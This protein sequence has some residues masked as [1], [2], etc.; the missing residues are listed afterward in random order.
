VNYANIGGS[1]CQ[2]F[3]GIVTTRIERRTTWAPVNSA[4]LTS[5]FRLNVST[6][7]RLPRVVSAF[8]I[9]PASG[10]RP[11]YA[12]QSDANPAIATVGEASL[13]TW[14]TRISAL[15]CR[16][17]PQRHYIPPAFSLE[18][19]DAVRVC[20]TSLRPAHA[21]L[22]LAQV[23]CRMLLS[24]AGFE[25]AQVVARSLFQALEANTGTNF[26]GMRSRHAGA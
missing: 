25:N 14:L 4:P 18:E 7:S 21:P 13:F 1:E 5:F 26:G 9:R 22:A 8:G 15:A 2:D 23:E 12:H 6:L 24:A 3:L 11:E 16:R 19:P 20:H 10:H 17:Q